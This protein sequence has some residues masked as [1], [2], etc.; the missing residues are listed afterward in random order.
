MEIELVGL[1]VEK[2]F[3][4]KIKVL[5]AR[6]EHSLLKEGFSSLYYIP[7]ILKLIQ[8]SIISH[9]IPQKSLSNFLFLTFH[10]VLNTDVIHV[11]V[12]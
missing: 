12:C 4:D 7:M 3:V 1:K 2:L 10:Q 9:K 11:P 5:K 6:L 8:T